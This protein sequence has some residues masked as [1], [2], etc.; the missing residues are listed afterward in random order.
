[1]KISSS[2][3]NYAAP[4]FS[5]QPF[6]VSPY[7]GDTAVVAPVSR[8][9]L[10]LWPKALLGVTTLATVLTPIAILNGS[11]PE[12]NVWFAWLGEGLATVTSGLL[13]FEQGLFAK[14]AKQKKA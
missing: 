13:A 2:A 12:H 3:I 5:A 1:M 7:F 8:R 14:N 10:N 6:V 4:R 9:N 11:V